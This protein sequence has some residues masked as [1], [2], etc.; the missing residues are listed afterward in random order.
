MWIGAPFS[1]VHDELERV[2]ISGL[3]RRA[4]PPADAQPGFQADPIQPDRPF[5]AIGDIHGSL[6]LLEQ[7]LEQIDADV[8][9]R[10]ETAV[11]LVLLGDY[12][13][14]GEGS[15]QVLQR[16]EQLSTLFPEQ[17]TCLKGNHEQ[18]MIDFLADPARAGRR[19]LR[20]GG[21]QTLASYGVGGVSDMSGPR[22]LEE[23]AHALRQ[24]I[25]EE[26]LSWLEGLPSLWQSGNVVCVHA[27]LD[28]ER[29]LADH[30]EEI[31]IWGH[32]RFAQVPRQDGLWVIHGHTVVADPRVEGGRI[33][34]DLGAYYSGRLCAAAVAPGGVDFLVAGRD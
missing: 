21:L 6:G 9:A 17:V 20:N 3:F 22:A 15:A 4:S 26:V 28:P 5:Y 18:M 31:L 19:W 32:P 33:S 29:A 25:P 12:V 14:R 11:D 1:P 27:G 7:L 2:M 24:Q 34:V 16:L 8:E 30:P 23:A 13:D 10:G